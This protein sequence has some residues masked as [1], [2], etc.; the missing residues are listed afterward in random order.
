MCGQGYHLDHFFDTHIGTFNLSEQ[1][2]LE[3]LIGKGWL[4]SLHVARPSFPLSNLP[5]LIRHSYC[6]FGSSSIY[7]QHKSLGFRIVVYCLRS[8][9]LLC[10]Y[11]FC[12]PS[13]QGFDST[14]PALS[15]CHLQSSFSSP[16]MSVIKASFTLPSQ[17]LILAS[18]SSSVK[19]K[20]VGSMLQ[21]IFRDRWSSLT[22]VAFKLTI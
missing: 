13:L 22:L 15:R 3:M 8:V 21:M 14:P 18:N 5:C 17:L 4:D 10:G 19:S 1:K 2:R 12:L 11:D 7:A 16:V 9:Y 20:A 6:T